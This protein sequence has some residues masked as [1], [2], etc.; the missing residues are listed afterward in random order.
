MN[1]PTWG[2]FFF[3]L[4]NGSKRSSVSGGREWALLSLLHDEEGSRVGGGGESGVP[5][6]QLVLAEPAQDLLFCFILLRFLGLC[7]LLLASKVLLFHIGNCIQIVL[8]TCPVDGS[9]L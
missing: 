7:D 8:I 3:F 6:L 5:H 1:I 4:L 9:W 2:I